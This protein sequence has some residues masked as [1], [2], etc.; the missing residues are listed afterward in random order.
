MDEDKKLMELKRKYDFYSDEIR[1]LEWKIAIT[2]HNNDIEDLNK[3][4]ENCV[5]NLAYILDEVE[6]YCSI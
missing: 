1:S 3:I 4:L 6:E 2:R 5:E